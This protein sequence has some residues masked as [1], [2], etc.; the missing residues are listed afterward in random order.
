ML[1]PRDPFPARKAPLS[2]VTGGSGFI[3]RH[4]VRL[5]AEKGHALRVLDLV[6]SPGLDPRAEFFQGSILDAALVRRVL[7]DADYVFHLAAN[8]DLWAP[9]KRTFHETNYVGTCV[10]LEEAERAHLRRFVHCSTESILKGVRNGGRA[11][12]NE[13][14]SRTVADMPG[15]YCRSKFLAER[16]ALA[17]AGRGLPVVIVNPTLPIGPGDLRLTPPTR[18]LL[19]FVNG[20][21]PAYLDFATNM[22]DVRDAALG[23]WLAAE[24]GRVSERYI[25]GGENVRLSQVLAMLS[26]LTG[27]RMPRLRVPYALALAAAAISELM[28]DFV[29]RRPPKAPLTGV[30]LAGTSMT[31]DCARAEQ[32]LGLQPRPIRRAL[33]DA[34]VWLRSEGRIQRSLSLAPMAGL[35]ALPA[36]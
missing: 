25:L 15:P 34:V 27:L 19:D 12:A 14:V 11:L 22:I 5:L 10:V 6:A 13:S 30:R 29:T 36:T 26:D 16:A 4:L 8:P 17:A 33:A 9:D 20:E 1:E 7:T 2:V 24:R 3:G 21:N 32:E 23:H 31:F 28:A 18:M 35:N